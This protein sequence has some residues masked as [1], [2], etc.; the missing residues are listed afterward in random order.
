MAS[1]QEGKKIS[2]TF[3]GD[4]ASLAS[5][6]RIS[7]F[8]KKLVTDI[9][10]NC[11]GYHL[12]DVPIAIKRHG[13]EPWHDEGGVTAIAVLT[14]SHIAIHTWPEDSGAR[15][16]VDSCRDFD[17]KVI[18][19]LLLEFFKAHDIKLHDVSSCFLSPV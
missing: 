6:G 3:R 7:D 12:Y 10:M 5:P 8:L 13:Q 4:K 2:G 15:I 1:F 17:A 9:G 18:E 19:G 16:D 11:L 14:T